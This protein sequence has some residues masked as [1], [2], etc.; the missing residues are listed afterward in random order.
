MTKS[1]YIVIA[2]YDL[3]RKITKEECLDA[4]QQDEKDNAIFIDFEVGNSQLS[5]LY[6]LSFNNI[7]L[8]QQRK[9]VELVKPALE[10]NPNA[11]IAYFGYT[12][13]PISFHFGYLL[14]N[15]RPYTIYQRRGN[16][17]WFKET[18]KP[19]KE[20]EFSIKPLSLPNEEQKGKGKV[21]I[22]VATS[23]DIEK[24][25]TYEVVPN[26]ENEFDIYLEQ[27]HIDSLYSQ[28]NIEA[29]VNAFQEVLNAYSS[30]LSDREKIHLF[31][32][33]SCGLPFALGTRINPNM[34]PY[35]QTY[36]Y[37]SSESP[38]YREAVL[39]TKEVDDRIILTEE[40]RMVA[41]TIRDSW[42]KQL[43]K[44]L[45]PFI[46]TISGKESENWLQMLCSDKEYESVSQYLCHPWS[47]VTDISKTSIKTDFIDTERTDV[48][49]SFEYSEKMNTWSFDDGFLYGLKNRLDQKPETDVMQAARLFFFHEA[50]HYSNEGHRLTREIADGI[51]QFPKV[52]EEADYQADVWGLLTEYKYCS[53][54]EPDQLKKGLKVFFCN[55][56]ET[57]VETMWSFSDTGKDLHLI[58]IR[59]MNRFLNWYWQ[60]VRIE[61]IDGTGTLKEIIQILFDKPVIEFAGAQMELRGY[62]TYFK[63]NSR[64][65]KNYQLAA[66][67]SNKVYR[68]SPN[69]I[70][71]IVDGF[72]FLDGEKIKAGL[73]SFWTT[74]G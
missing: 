69:L 14:G 49:D 46:E 58:Q 37:S 24:Q 73:K 36:Q 33:A 9:F 41:R 63:L 59:S 1:K 20:Y 29:V 47:S 55:A 50:L 65:Y 34:Y 54:Y 43:Q 19:T 53:I 35:I 57:A 26:P 60:W 74:L 25:S 4:L 71:E 44:G 21:I 2:H 31:I 23:T 64:Q 45:K 70:D 61:K 5:E 51:G 11:R 27:T 66:F 72:R 15:S 22:R 56:I 30:K 67:S 12:S 17:P 6:D 48:D 10:E 42:E 7:A 32:S 18:N 40:N 16:K 8:L 3:D 62:K 52:V 13:I 68:F 39:V 38:K 28:E